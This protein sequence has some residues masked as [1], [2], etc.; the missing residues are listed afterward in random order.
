MRQK[1]LEEMNRD[2]LRVA[3]KKVG[4]VGRGSMSKSDLLSALQALQA[5]QQP[6]HN[7]KPT[8]GQNTLSNKQRRRRRLALRAA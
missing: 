4:L 2:E 7:P 8:R 6:R 3:A 1:N 5:K